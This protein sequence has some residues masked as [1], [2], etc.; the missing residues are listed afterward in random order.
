MVSELSNIHPSNSAPSKPRTQ[1]KV[2][3]RP[4]ASTTAPLVDLAELTQLVE[5]LRELGVTDFS[6][7]D[8]HLTLAHVGPP[9]SKPEQEP[10]VIAGPPQ[11]GPASQE[12]SDEDLLFY[13]ADSI[14]P[15]PEGIK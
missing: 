9:L 3:K 12:L 2:A 1:I 13:S 5:K 14:G 8:L 7:G 4:P 15:A 10:S 6:N 11:L